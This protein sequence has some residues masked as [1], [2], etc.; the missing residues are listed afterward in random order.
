MKYMVIQRGITN[1]SWMIRFLENGDTE[2]LE[3]SE[4]FE[5]LHYS[6]YIDNDVVRI[7]EQ[8]YF[9]NE[10]ASKELWQRVWIED[11]Q[12]NGDDV[13]MTEFSDFDEAFEFLGE[14]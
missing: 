1:A 8:N 5:Q 6:E 2:I 9:W 14:L 3:S 7:D 11:E 13:T 10:W 12:E 4:K